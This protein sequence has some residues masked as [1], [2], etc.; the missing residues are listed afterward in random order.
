MRILKYKEMEHE[1]MD[2]LIR[3]TIEC[4]GRLSWTQ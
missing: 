3:L 1:D 2:G 4:S